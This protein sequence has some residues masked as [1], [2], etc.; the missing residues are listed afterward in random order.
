MKQYKNFIKW[1][2][3]GI[4]LR[5]W[6]CAHYENVQKRMGRKD[7]NIF[8]QFAALDKLATVLHFEYGLDKIILS[9]GSE[10]LCKWKQSHTKNDI[11]IN[12]NTEMEKPNFL[13]IGQE[14]AKLTA[15]EMERIRK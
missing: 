5:R 3:E 13:P 12:E 6:I 10:A 9:K 2:G 1:L 11:Y 8:K 4:H 15:I 7:W 14:S